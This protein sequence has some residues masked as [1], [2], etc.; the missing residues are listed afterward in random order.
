MFLQA[1][2]VTT[3]FEEQANLLTVSDLEAWFWCL[4]AARAVGFYNSDRN[5]G[6]SQ[7]HKHMQFIPL[8][9]FAEIRGS[10]LHVSITFATCTC[11]VIAI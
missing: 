11:S 5:A 7:P 3:Q 8:D 2:L 9:V 6:A 10:R 4:N 1:L